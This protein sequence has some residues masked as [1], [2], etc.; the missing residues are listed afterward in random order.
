VQAWLWL[1]PGD[2]PTAL[3]WSITSLAL[4]SGVTYAGGTV[5]GSG[6]AS[7]FVV[8]N[9]YGYDIYQVTFSV[10]APLTLTPGTYWLNLMNGTTASLGFLFWDQSTGP[11]AGVDSSLGPIPSES[12][13]LLTPSSSIY[14]ANFGFMTWN[15]DGYAIN[16]G[17]SVSN[18]FPVT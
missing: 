9:S 11:S 6:L 18:S 1:N 4:N 16:F 17:F 7:V 8:T 10:G 15:T 12:F 3:Q 2:T 13:N 5:S 14:Y